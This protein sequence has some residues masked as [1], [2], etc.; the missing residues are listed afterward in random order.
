MIVIVSL[1][2]IENYLT[3]LTRLHHVEALLELC[4]GEVVSDH[5]CEVK[6]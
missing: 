4:Y 1:L 5:R 3:A 6:T 2:P